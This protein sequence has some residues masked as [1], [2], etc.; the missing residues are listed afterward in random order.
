MAFP[1]SVRRCGQ[2]RKVGEVWCGG[3]WWERARETQDRTEGGA[4]VGEEGVE[5]GLKK[6]AAVVL[7]RAEGDHPQLAVL[8]SWRQ[9]V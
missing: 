8:R 5:S 2:Q 7:L 4:V 3:G 1:Y 9:S 6:G